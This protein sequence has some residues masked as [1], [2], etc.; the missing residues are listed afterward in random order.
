[1]GQSY[2][3]RLAQVSF[4]AAVLLAG[5]LSYGKKAR[6]ADPT[7]P[8]VPAGVRDNPAARG[9]S[10]VGS[11][12]AALADL[13]GKLQLAQVKVGKAAA[14]EEPDVV[15]ARPTLNSLYDRQESSTRDA[16]NKL[17]AAGN[18]SAKVNAAS[19]DIQA[20]TEDVRRFLAA[21]PSISSA[22]SRRLS[23]INA[24]LSMI[25]NSPDQYASLLKKVG[26]PD[27]NLSQAKATVQIAA[28]RS[29]GKLDGDTTPD[30]L[31][32]RSEVRGM[33]STKQSK[34]LDGALVGGK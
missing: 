8:T 19:S 1:M 32:T 11:E 13:K 10:G 3:S 18:D 24:E 21:N 31:S 34:A 28:T 27:P 4:A 14:N 5:S 17:R 26:V 9:S 6:P 12:Q 2:N 33:L 20:A 23:I 7:T 16:L 25:A 15:D 30:V 29:R 22:L